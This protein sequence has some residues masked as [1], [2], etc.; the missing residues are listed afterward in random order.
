MNYPTIT[1]NNP[2]TYSYKSL[3]YRM[4]HKAKRLD[5]LYITET[6]LKISAYGLESTRKSLK[7]LNYKFKI[8]KNRKTHTQIENIQKNHSHKRC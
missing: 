7:S 4:E 5:F 8:Q 3:L 2:H 6:C 1:K